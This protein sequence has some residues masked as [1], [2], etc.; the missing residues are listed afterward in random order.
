M[1]DLIVTSE[2]SELGY[3]PRWL[4]WGFLDRDLFRAQLREFAELR[5]FGTGNGQDGD[6]CRYQMFRRALA[7][8]D[9]FN[10]EELERFLTLVE[11]DTDRGMAEC[12]IGDL[13]RSKRIN[14]SQIEELQNREAVHLPV[15]QRLVLRRKLL[16]ELATGNLT[17][18]LFDRCL[19][20]GDSVVQRELVS[21][22]GLTRGQL[23]TLKDSGVNR[24][25]RNLAREKLGRR[26]V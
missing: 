14:I 9:P 11:V 6:H 21:L 22:G 1:I 24:A 17:D 12:V 2:L 15:F 20:R 23:E 18:D 26:K 3:D 5:D 19:A 7:R 25:I 16:A 10:P 13:L 8:T 4:E